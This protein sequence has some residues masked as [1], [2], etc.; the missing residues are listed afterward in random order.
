MAQSQHTPQSWLDTAVRDIPGKAER[1]AV[2]AEL[3]GHMQE[4][5]DSLQQTFPGLPPEEIQAQ[6]LTAMGD[7]EE[8]G[9]ALAQVH[10]PWPGRLLWLSRGVL[11]AVAV[12]L[13]VLL[14]DPPSYDLAR[15]ERADLWGERPHALGRLPGPL[16]Q[17]VGSFPQLLEAQGAQ[18]TQGEERYRVLGAQEVTLGGRRLF[19]RALLERWVEV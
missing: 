16:Y 9:R 3:S 13:V 6:A 11:L 14:S 18:L 15:E 4:R 5:M 12:S 2:W 10:S 19:E 1:R 7:A 17:F 8:I